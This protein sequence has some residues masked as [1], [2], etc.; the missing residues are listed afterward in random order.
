M[1][2]LFG[3]ITDDWKQIPQNIR[4]VLLFGVFSIFHTWLLDHWG[5]NV[6]LFF[7][8]NLREISY[9]LGVVF[10]VVGFILLVGKQLLFFYKVINYRLRYPLNKLDQDYYLVWFKGKLILFDKKGGK[11]YYHVH[12][13][14]TAQKLYF[15]NRG[16]YVEMQFLPKDLHRMSVNNKG[17]IINVAEYDNG[18]SINTEE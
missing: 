12:P 1:N 15:V 11:K 18:G 13:W 16:K 6:P 9:I 2:D 10:V 14:E 7:G 5:S 4:Y 3:F 17:D 8:V